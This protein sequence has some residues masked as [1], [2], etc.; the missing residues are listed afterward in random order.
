MCV[1]KNRF[2]GEIIG[3][4]LTNF[5]Y[6]YDRSVERGYRSVR[7]HGYGIPEEAIG[8]R[9]RF[10]AR[11]P[12]DFLKWTRQKQ[13]EHIAGHGYDL[14]VKLATHQALVKAA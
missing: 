9:D 5:D 6:I 7:G 3:S 1:I 12:G 13:V 11:L 2:L 4:R 8:I 10:L 14:G